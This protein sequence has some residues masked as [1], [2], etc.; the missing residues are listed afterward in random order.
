MAV[1]KVAITLS[2][3]LLARVDALAAAAGQTRS[4]FVQT[5]LEQTLAKLEEDLTVREARAIYEAIES[6]PEV[7]WMHNAFAAAIPETLPEYVAP[8]DGEEQRR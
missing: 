8:S 6:D 7:R 5:S 1:A 2:P 3:E 4:A